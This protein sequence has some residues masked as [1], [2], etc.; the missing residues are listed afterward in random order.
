MTRRRQ[1]ATFASVAAGIAAAACG[2]EEAKP[3]APAAKAEPTRAPAASAPEPT[4]AAAAPAP[5]TAAA[6]AAQPVKITW[7]AGRDTTAFTP[8][9]VEEFNKST[10]GK[11]TIDYQEQGQ[12]TSDLRDKFILVANAKDPA[13]DLV[14]MDVPFVPEFA[15]AG[16]TLDMDKVLMPDEKSKF[17][18]GTLDGATYSGKLYAVPW[19]NNGPGLYYRKD[20]IEQGGFK[21]PPKSYDELLEQA[22]KL[23]TAEI[24]GFSAQMSQTEGGIIIWMEYLWG[25]G[26]DLT[27]E[28]RVQDWCGRTESFH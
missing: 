7:F 9:Q 23:Q 19:Y 16:W 18:K 22:K 24:A 3:A 27:D 11:I 2:G 25:Y 5:T 10:S 26:G 12:Q 20:L 14:S 13:A 15:A 1:L 4:K 28:K 21:G 8:K 6:P 17:F